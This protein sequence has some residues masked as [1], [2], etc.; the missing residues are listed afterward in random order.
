MFSFYDQNELSLVV[1]EGVKIN[2]LAETMRGTSAVLLQCRPES[3][4]NDQVI[5]TVR[6]VIYA[7]AR[8]LNGHSDAAAVLPYKE[9]RSIGVENPGGLMGESQLRLDFKGG[10]SIT[11]KFKGKADVAALG[12]AVLAVIG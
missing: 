11:F 8:D 6:N 10:K 1:N 9:V 12:K 3:N 7:D 2:E 4:R 5:F